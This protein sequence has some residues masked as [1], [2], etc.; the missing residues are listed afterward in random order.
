MK[1]CVRHWLLH[2]VYFNLIHIGLWK[3]TNLTVWNV[4]AGRVCK[5]E[6]K[7]T[8]NTQSGMAQCLLCRVIFVP[9]CPLFFT[10]FCWSCT[11]TT[12]P[13]HLLFW[14]QCSC[15]VCK[16][17]T[18]IKGSPMMSRMHFCC[19]TEANL[20]G[21]RNRNKETSIVPE[22]FR[23]CLLMLKPVLIQLWRIAIWGQ[24][25]PLLITLA[26]RTNEIRLANGKAE[27]LCCNACKSKKKK[28]RHQQHHVLAACLK[29]FISEIGML[30]FLNCYALSL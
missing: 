23:E 22:L 28:K 17:H 2:L 14:M 18:G 3:H 8:R 4:I 29:T 6:N 15:G 5:R 9:L 16:L 30:L 10:H 7:V 21:F 24:F 26:T 11:R 20:F 13:V 25:L 1:S 27:L 12:S 19:L